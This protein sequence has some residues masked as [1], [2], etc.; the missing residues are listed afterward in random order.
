MVTKCP[1]RYLQYDLPEFSAHTTVGTVR[2]I[3]TRLYYIKMTEHVTFLSF[4][5]ASAAGTLHS[6]F[7]SMCNM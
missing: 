6:N 3:H 5:V 1:T 4:G 2:M 7:H